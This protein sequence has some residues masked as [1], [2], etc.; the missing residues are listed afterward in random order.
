M[1]IEKELPNVKELPVEQIVGYAQPELM[2]K[3]NVKKFPT[4]IVVDEDGEA[5]FTRPGFTTADKID[6]KINELRGNTS[7][8]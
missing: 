1:E 6:K 4:L 2:Q 5:L 3:Y 7:V 8:E